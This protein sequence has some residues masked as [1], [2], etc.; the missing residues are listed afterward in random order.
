MKI[1]LNDIKKIDRQKITETLIHYITCMRKC[2][3]Q[4][5]CDDNSSCSEF[6]KDISIYNDLLGNNLSTDN[7]IVT[8]RRE[9][10]ELLNGLHED[11]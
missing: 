11:N 5:P 7:R 6:S 3:R 10:S 2:R 8:L 1:D 4:W 9:V